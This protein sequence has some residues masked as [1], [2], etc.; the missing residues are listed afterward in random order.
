MKTSIRT[1]RSSILAGAAATLAVA[2]LGFAGAAQAR[3]SVSWSVG[4]GIP[5]SVVN[6]GNVGSVYPQ[7]I[8]VQPQP[9]YVQPQPV[10]VQPA[11]RYYQQQQQPVYL[12]PPPN[13]YQPRPVFVRPAPVYLAPQPIY[14]ERERRHGHHGHHGRHDGGNYVQGNGYGQGYGQV[15]YQRDGYRGDRHDD[16]R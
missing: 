7:P 12:E 3:D 6:V 14:Y 10:Y 15:Y 11:P 8:Y 2:A 13:Y 16:R 1:T 4:V 5:G 9:V